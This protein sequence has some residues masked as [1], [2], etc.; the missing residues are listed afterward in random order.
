[1]ATRRRSKKVI[2]FLLAAAFPAVFVNLGHGHNGFLMGGGPV[3]LAYGVQM[4]VTLAL[5][6][7]VVW[8][9]R[10]G[11]SARVKAAG[12]IIA[13][14]L[15]TPYSLDYDLMVLAPAIAFWAM[16]GLSRGFRPWEKTT[17]AGLWILPLIA[18][19]FPEAT[20]IPLAAPLLLAAFAL[21]LRRAANET[22]APLLWI[23]PRRIV[24]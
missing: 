4:V 10:S 21:L 11:A 23:S 15:G 1:L 3:P 6:V 14:L 20:S 18:R 22:G 9:W 17:L 16:D 24:R 2:H 8:L 19:S 12:L 5:A 13:A 7:A